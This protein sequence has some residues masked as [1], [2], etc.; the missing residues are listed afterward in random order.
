MCVRMNGNLSPEEISS[1]VRQVTA[2]INDHFEDYVASIPNGVAMSPAQEPAHQA[3][4]AGVAHKL[5]NSILLDND[6]D[7]LVPTISKLLP[8]GAEVDEIKLRRLVREMLK[9]RRTQLAEQASELSAMADRRPVGP[10]PFDGLKIHY[11]VVIDPGDEMSRQI[12]EEARTAK[13]GDLSQFHD[14]M[15]KLVQEELDAGRYKTGDQLD[16]EFAASR[17]VRAIEAPELAPEPQP[18]SGP[19]MSEIYWK[20]VD[21]LIL[22]KQWAAGSDK[23]AKAPLRL[24]TKICG[25]KPL[26]AYSLKDG[27]F[28]RS[29]VLRLP[30]GYTKA[31]EWK[32]F[33]EAGKYEELAA[34]AAVA[35][36][37][38]EARLACVTPKTWNS[39]LSK[40]KAVWIV[41]HQNDWAPSPECPF[42]SLA[43]D[44]K[45]GKAKHDADARKRDMF[46]DSDLERIFGDP[47]FVGP[48]EEPQKVNGD[49]IDLH[50]ERYW[51]T[52]GAA[53]HGPRR[54]EIAQLKVRHVKW[55]HGICYLD[56]Q[57]SDGWLDLKEEG[58]W[59]LIPIHSQ[60]LRLG[61]LEEC[62]T[63]RNPEA[64]LF[65]KRPLV[66]SVARQKET[67]DQVSE[68]LGKFFGRFKTKLGFAGQQTFHSFRHTVSTKLERAGVPGH[69]V[70]AI[71]GHK[72]SGRPRV[73]DVYFHGLTLADL[74]PAIEKLVLPIDVD[75]LR[76]ARGLADKVEG[77]S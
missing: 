73:R 27:S 43:I 28:L 20:A 16:A 35:A 37:T 54:G 72:D 36:E 51:G 53:Y 17:P 40:L 38:S 32:S 71:I 5:I 55:A 44:L 46:H 45:K 6:I 41:A 18:L 31:P 34:A 19:L 13:V 12:L 67:V 61:F 1:L 62:V 63:G 26:A 64:L 33:H 10:E 8:E 76:A 39:H 21:H 75:R 52:L 69:F 42:A 22:T 2:P 60:M 66:G 47:L 48:P 24:L 70:S 58:S 77:A 25:D 15:Q 29:V 9:G 74:K 49:L 65:S 68:S 11:S 3:L 14:H 7:V 59:R 4:M 57:T 50:F 30:A 56:L 23:K